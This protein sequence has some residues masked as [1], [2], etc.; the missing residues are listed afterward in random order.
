MNTTSQENDSMAK[1]DMLVNNLIYRQPQQLSLAVNRTMKRQRFQLK[2]YDS[3]DT[4]TINWNTGSDYIKQYNSYL[5]FTL[6][7]TGTGTPTAN[8]G[9]GSAINVI[10]SLIIN[11]KSA[12]L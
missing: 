12:L 5:T 8:F 9:V 11:T 10:E 7:L 6:K 4:A 1:G 2:N 3:G